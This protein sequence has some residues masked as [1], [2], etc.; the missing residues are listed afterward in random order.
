MVRRWSESEV[1]F[2]KANYADKSS[3]QLAKDLNR[4]PK[5]IRNKAVSLNLHA[6]HRY[7]GHPKPVKTFPVSRELVY[8]IG[9]IKGDGYL[10]SN[11]KGLYSITLTVKDFEFVHRVKESI[12]HIIGRFPKIGVLQQHSTSIGAG[13][14]MYR[15]TVSDKSLFYL[16]KKDLESLKQHIEIYPSDFLRGFFDAE[17]SAWIVKR[18]NRKKRI[19]KNGKISY[20]N[21]Y[22]EESV[23][24]YCN[25][26][27]NLMDYIRSLLVNLSIFPA[28]KMFIIK[29]NL[30]ENPKP[31][32]N[33]HVYR[34]DSIKRF[35]TL[36]G[37]SIPR[38]RL[39]L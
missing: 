27:K 26:D 16:L 14:K 21:R 38:K 6:I 35:M 18:Q 25:T 31:C 13:N 24:K 11:Q 33:L 23:V 3:R 1:S 4:T 19:V 17:G 12:G 32:Y 5:A 28:P 37:S 34:K 30:C 9:A 15:V 39:V 36:I 8:L 29:G 20:V 2:L 22:S 10:Y 7:Y